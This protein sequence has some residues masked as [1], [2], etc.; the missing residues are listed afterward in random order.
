MELLLG[1][2]D[3]LILSALTTIMLL[4]SSEFFSPRYGMSHFII[5]KDRLRKVAVLDSIVFIILVIIRIYEIIR[6]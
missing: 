2:N 6:R 3:L 1:N 5:R 4:I